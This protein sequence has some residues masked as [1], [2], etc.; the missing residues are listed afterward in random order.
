MGHNNFP[1]RFTLIQSQKASQTAK[2]Y[3]TNIK[4]MGEGKKNFYIKDASKQ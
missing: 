2:N 1:I 4:T 3:P